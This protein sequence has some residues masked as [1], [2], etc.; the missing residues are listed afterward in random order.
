MLKRFNTLIW[1]TSLSLSLLLL[2]CW[3]SQG[4]EALGQ[5][6]ASQFNQIARATRDYPYGFGQGYMSVA[7]SPEQNS[8]EYEAVAQTGATWLRVM[9]DWNTIEGKK[10]QFNW[11]WL[12]HIVDEAQRHDLQVLGIIGFTPPWARLAGFSSLFPSA[13]PANPA[14]F[15]KF[16]AQVVQRYGNQ[17]AHWEIW[18]EPNLPIFFGF[19]AKRVERYAE[20]LKVAYPAIKAIQPESTVLVAGLSP[21]NGVDS[22]PGFLQQLY[23]AG[24]KGFFDAAAAHPYVFPDGLA[25]DPVNGWS[26]VDRM[27]QVMVAHGDSNKKIWLTELGAPTCDCNSGVSQQEQAKQITDL[28]TA[29]AR[30]SYTGPAFIYS[31]R[32]SNT[33]NRG[34]RESNM[35]ALLTTDWQPKFTASVL[36]RSLEHLERASS[37][38]EW[39]QSQ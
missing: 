6:W 38:H 37:T 12:D 9:I 16:C 36:V 33:A 29:A 2:N 28:L 11:G 35:G 34:S 21:L 26:D 32:D 27:H 15:A 23:D 25:V 30:T 1:V 31:I 7:N 14:D 3:A 17:I 19:A 22:P 24:I 10:G 13:P 4:T 20:M 8:R 5:T 18:N 39:H